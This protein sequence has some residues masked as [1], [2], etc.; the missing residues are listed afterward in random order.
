VLQDRMW[1]PRSAIKVSARA[2]RPRRVFLL[3]FAR[4]ITIMLSTQKWLG[5]SSVSTEESTSEFS[6]GPRL[7]AYQFLRK[8]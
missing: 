6:L 3:D 1:H 8:T 2:C 5:S 4:A 7:P